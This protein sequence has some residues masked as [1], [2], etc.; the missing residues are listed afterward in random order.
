[1]NLKTATSK[2]IECINDRGML[3]V[4]PVNNRKDPRSLWSEFYPRS[5]MRW[6]WDETGDDRVSTMWHLRERLSTSRRVVYTKWYRG[7]ATVISFELFR[8]MLALLGS[9]RD[10]DQGLSFQSQEILDLLNEDSPLSTK[11]LKHMA[12][13]R[14]R[15]RERLYNRAMKDLWAR[16]FIVAFGEVDEGAFPSLAIGSTRV[17]FED[18]WEESLGIGE[19]EARSVLERH[20]PQGSLFRKYFDQVMSEVARLRTEGETRFDFS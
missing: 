19:A 10:Q 9:S 17:L 15:E 1:M 6:E 20:L 5:E 3:L 18:L 8:A 7:R 2:A 16:L 12:D 14:G 4:Y 13:L 11:V